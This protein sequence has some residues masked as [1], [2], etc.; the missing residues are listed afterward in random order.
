MQFREVFEILNENGFEQ[1]RQKGSHC[2]FA[3]MIGGRKRLVTV[4][5]HKL[6]DDVKKGTLASIRRQSGLPKKAFRK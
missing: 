3:G 1:T 2:Q 6:S 5:C 4:A